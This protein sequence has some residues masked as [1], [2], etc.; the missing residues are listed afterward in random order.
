MAAFTHAIVELGQR[1]RGVLVD[2]T[3]RLADD[4]D[5]WLRLRAG[6]LSVESLR[7]LRDGVWFDGG[8]LHVSVTGLAVRT[9]E[10]HLAVRGASTA[11]CTD[12]RELPVVAAQWRWLSLFVPSDLLIAARAAAAGLPPPSDHVDIVSPALSQVL[13]APVAQTHLHV[14]AASSFAMLWTGLMGSLGNDWPSTRSL[15]VSPGSLPFGSGERLVMILLAA[16]ITRTMLAAYLW[17]RSLGRAVGPLQEFLEAALPDRPGLAR[18]ARAVAWPWGDAEARRALQGALAILATGGAG[19]A[20]VALLSDLYRRIVGAP[21]ARA[22][23]SRGRSV[24]T[25]DPLSDWLPPAPASALPE[26]RF[27]REAIG[28]LWWAENRGARDR[29]FELL[30]WQYTRVRC[31]L[32]RHLVQEPGTAG[33]DWFVQYYGRISSWRRPLES[34]LFEGALELESIG[35]NLQSLETRTS[36]GQ[37]WIKIRQLVRELATQACRFGPRS[38]RRRPEVGLVLHFIKESTTRGQGPHGVERRM[39]ADPEH[40]AFRARYG[41]WFV[42][43]QHEA[44]AIQTLLGW[45][46]DFLLLLR[47]LD[48]AS[49][50]LAIPTW[51]L[52]PLIRQLHQASVR[53]AAELRHRLPAAAVPPLRQTLHVGED[54]R[55]LSEGLRRVHEAMEFGLV[56]FGDRVGHA[57]ALGDDPARWTMKHQVI[58]QPREER[59][60][61][62]LWE[63][64]RYQ[65]AEWRP[66]AERLEAVRAEAAR[67]GR[68][69]YGNGPPPGVDAL[70]EARRLRHD[71]DVLAHLGYPTR[72]ELHRRRDVAL[73]LVARHLAD[74]DVFRTGFVPLPVETTDAEVSMLCA[75]QRWLREMLGG[76][77]ITVEINP[78]SNLLIGD[79]PSLTDHPLFQLQPVDG[80]SAPD[81]SAVLVSVNDDDPLVFATKLSDEFTYLYAALLQR[82][83]LAQPALAF[84][85]RLRRNGWRSRFTI[86][87]SRDGRLLRRLCRW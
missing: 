87:A 68:A 7:Q 6:G 64:D 79:L 52:I 70:V 1:P 38:R 40:G 21:A 62:L 31:L 23:R 56:G 36:P 63:L 83:I 41:P 51:V 13:E 77:E 45:R 57:F 24:V 53:A 80:E 8:T 66:S 35:L 29:A 50:E 81:R 59:L 86:P 84:L 4:M 65:H 12:H 46:P 19:R 55:R 75:G 67:L 20:P 33:L 58:Y 39:L 82:G 22:R 72:V 74:P 18:I 30:F 47:G 71:P 25:A 16:A 73:E 10:A 54:Y 61:D 9:A 43:R 76:R 17:E 37:S 48:V 2:R 60:D 28:Y 5:E 69:I 15:E 42:D 14:G 32:Y 49:T 44:W 3:R 78:S 11:L 27:A 34:H 26:T 85:N